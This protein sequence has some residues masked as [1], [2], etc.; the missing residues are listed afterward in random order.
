MRLGK[1]QDLAARLRSHEEYHSL[2]ARTMQSLWLRRSTATALVGVMLSLAVTTFPVA[3]VLFAEETTIGEESTKVQ[4]GPA[5]RR[6]VLD[7]STL[8]LEGCDATAQLL[9]HGETQD[10][11]V[12]DFTHRSSYTSLNPDIVAI[13]P[14]G[15][16]TAINDGQT[17]VRVAAAGQEYLLAVR[18]KNSGHR[19]PIHFEN[20]I[21]PILNKF[22]CNGSGCHGKA[23]GQN[24]FKLSVFGFDPVAD[25][26]ALVFEGRGRRVFPA[27]PDTSLLLEKINGSQPH[28]G[29]IRLTRDR[30]EYRLLRDWIGSG[31]PFGEAT[32]R[33]VTSVEVSPRERRL[34]IGGSQQLR[35]TAR[36]SDGQSVD[37]T[38]L[39]RFQSNHEGLASV[40]EAGRITVGKSPGVVA[41]MATFAGHVDVFQAVIPRSEQMPSDDSPLVFNFIDEH[42]NDRLRQLRIRPSALCDDHDFLRRVSIDLI[43]TLPTAAETRDF[44]TD[45][46]PNRRAKI[47]DR[48]LQ[49]SEFADYWALK[50]SDLLRVDRL[51]LGH[52]G[53]YAYYDW[54]RDSFANNQPLDRFARQLLTA[55]G[56]L[57]EAPA[58]H[59]YR[60]VK[61]PEEMASTLSQ[62]LLG[63]RIECAQC[64]HHPFDRWSQ[65]DYFGMQAYFTQVGFKT[66]P[67]GE[68][69]TTLANRKTTHPRKAY[70]IFPYPLGGNMP[71]TATEGDRRREL[72]EWLVDKNNQWFARN[73]ANRTWAHVM[74]RGLVEPVDD[75]RSTNPPSNPKLLDALAEALVDSG[76]DFRELLR[77]IT[78][79]AAYQRSAEV[80]DTNAKDEQNYSRHLLKPLEAEVLLDAVCQTTGVP[81]KF[82]G[83]PAGSR[84][85]QLWDS[86]VAHETLKLFGRPIRA[87][88]CECERVSEPTVSQVLH[89]LNSPRI[90]AKLSHAAGTVATLVRQE[91]QNQA[92]V[93]TLYLTFLA[94]FPTD[95]QLAAGVAYVESQ[96]N[97]QQAAE[98]LA[99]S[100]LNSVEFLF[101]H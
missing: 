30:P 78:A 38:N 84:A 92:L 63:V 57:T 52:K 76:F 8:T 58:A 98:D 14:G 66:G 71:A 88:A 45:R 3:R 20:D 11:N 54:I 100:M 69:L 37:V 72:A 2:T 6:I 43:G 94:R 56:P 74:G 53:A 4:A 27:A 93:E 15:I 32:V 101:N 34:A 7:P 75:F 12:T 60:V 17:H 9:V 59:F 39:T 55:A 79:S 96:A 64:H 40:D 50:W 85:I 81:E 95:Q 33:Q 16:A 91:P 36:Y 47:V 41:V 31:L 10:G 48:L 87:T 90:Q 22:G 29:G 19:P 77:T 73:L 49:R 80:N 70:E 68:S 26:Q 86:G 99:W 35:V 46:S 24:G 89:V 28:G 23:E 83:V 25:Y 51:E 97:R 82:S 65:Q 5:F 61:K 21:V 13:S 62:V 42:V 44:L 67:T 18:V 1:D